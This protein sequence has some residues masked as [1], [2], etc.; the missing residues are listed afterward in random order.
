M[1][2]IYAAS[3][4]ELL[5]ESILLD[6]KLRASAEALDAQFQAVTAAARE[7]LHLPRF[8]ELSGNIIDYLAEQFHIDFYE[9]LY[10]TEAE[11]VNMI[12]SSIAWHRIKGTPAAVEQIAHAAF[13]DAD[14]QEW[15]EYGGEPYH[16]KIKSHGYKETPD[17]FATYLRL[18][19]VAKNVR[20]W[21]DN[22]EVV[23][24]E[25][26]AVTYAGAIDLTTGAKDMLVARP[27]DTYPTEIFAG[28]ANFIYGDKRESLQLPK[29][30]FAAETLYGQILSKVGSIEID[31]STKSTSGDSLAYAW[32]SENFA[33]L[34]NLILGQKTWS[35][36]LA[37]N[38]TTKDY[39]G[40]AN[41]IFGDKVEGLH[42]PRLKFD[43][44]S[45]AAQILTK[46][47]AIKVDSSTKSSADN[48]FAHAWKGDVY[49][50]NANLKTGDL[51]IEPRLLKENSELLKFAVG[52]ALSKVG[53]IQL[54]KPN[55][56]GENLYSKAWAGKFFSGTVDGVFGQK[57]WS[58]SPPKDEVEKLHAGNANW[59]VGK[60]TES[61][62]RPNL[63]FE[64]SFAT[65]QMLTKTGGI[66][67]ET[68]T[69]PSVENHIAH[70]WQSNNF[71]GEANLKSG[72]VSVESDIAKDAEYTDEISIGQAVTKVGTIQIGT[73]DKPISGNHVD[74][75]GA[76]K[77]FADNV[78][79]KTGDFTIKRV[80]PKIRHKMVVR[81]GVPHVR[82]GFITI[83]CCPES[84]IWELPDDGDWLRLWFAFPKYGMKTIT[85]ANPREELERD[86]FN[87]VSNYVAGNGLLVNRLGQETTG[88]S[89]AAL[90]VN[91]ER[92]IF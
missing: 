79:L 11:K 2:N 91:R 14:I 43:E 64:T 52:Q 28:N 33:G 40:A 51:T 85:L 61:L 34:C 9:P 46:I 39:A 55:S 74:I 88:L 32:G 25:P 60:K 89:R 54:G 5:P 50:G 10:L 90:I 76:P 4:L 16:F 82:T 12:R 37:Q 63:N 15:F 24:D 62:N 47:G 65:G 30:K 21:I 71:V 67:V 42:R 48:T 58:M 49:A 26:E 6:P 36:S 92:K 45:F 57:Y 29:L 86:D 38:S 56:S 44:S 22:L 81:V 17:G 84:D 75:T 78:D 68:S 69:R 41:L 20:S 87:E 83:G 31:S 8:D 23:Y 1:K 7:V 66:Q 18:I 27:P 35:L 70:A 13:R 80:P 72:V 3:L 77:T 73:L 59:F 53:G 19:N